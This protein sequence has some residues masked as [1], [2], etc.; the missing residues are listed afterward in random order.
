MNRLPKNPPDEGQGFSRA[1]IGWRGDKG[2]QGSDKFSPKRRRRGPGNISRRLQMQPTE[3]GVP[4]YAI[5]FSYKC[6][7][8]TSVIAFSGQATTQ[9]P[10]A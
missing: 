1:I 2:T 6:L 4:I 8:V 9:S 10:H 3:R 5:P 7:F